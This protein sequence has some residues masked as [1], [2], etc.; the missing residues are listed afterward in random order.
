MTLPSF[1]ASS[2]ELL[3]VFS[4]SFFIY[5]TVHVRNR[6]RQYGFH[7]DTSTVRSCTCTPYGTILLLYTVRVSFPFHMYNARGLGCPLCGSLPLPPLACVLA[8]A[9]IVLKTSSP[10]FMYTSRTF[11]ANIHVPYGSFS[12]CTPYG[13]SNH[14]C[15]YRT[16]FSYFSSW[17]AAFITIRDLYF[18][19]RTGS[20]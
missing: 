19:H 16:G 5:R 17:C 1:S 3:F 12:C 6:N 4:C 2:S 10:D 20:V 18:L 11:L 15:M 13:S 7:F 8:H 14:K 9:S